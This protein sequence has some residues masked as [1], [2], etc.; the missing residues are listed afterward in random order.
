MFNHLCTCTLLTYSRSF[1]SGDMAAVSQNI[2]NIG[3]YPR[4]KAKQEVGTNHLVHV[5]YEDSEIELTVV[6]ED[7]MLA[8]AGGI[9]GTKVGY[10]IERKPAGSQLLERVCCGRSSTFLF[11]KML[12]NL[13]LTRYHC[14]SSH[15]KNKLAIPVQTDLLQVLVKTNK[16]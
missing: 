14:F 12:E 6:D 7:V 1:A 9:P 4:A 3:S 15:V 11:L 2:S 13:K 8:W 16:S 5:R 10:I